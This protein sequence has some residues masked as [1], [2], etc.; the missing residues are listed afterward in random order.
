M[1]LGWYF[2]QAEDCYS[3]LSPMSYVS[4][5]TENPSVVPSRSGFYW[6]LDFFV[7]NSSFL[8]PN[9]K[10]LLRCKFVRQVD[11]LDHFLKIRALES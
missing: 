2:S 9:F 1:M 4:I 3:N 7:A 5:N 11:S 10:H 8:F 6:L